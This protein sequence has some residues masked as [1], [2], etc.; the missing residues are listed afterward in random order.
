MRSEPRFILSKGS[1]V[2]Q[3]DKLKG[4]C[5]K[6]SYSFKTNEEVGYVLRDRTDCDFSIHSEESISLL[7]CPERIWFFAQGWDKEE[8]ASLLGKGI[9]R[10]VIDNPSDLEVFLQAIEDG[11]H[12]VDLLLRLRLKEHTIHTGKHFVFGFYSEQVKMMIPSLR[13]NPSIGRLG[14]H[15]HR[16]TQNVSEWSLKDE[17]IEAVGEDILGKIDLV[18]IGGGIPAEYRNF[19]QEVQNDIFKKIAELY[20]YLTSR[21]ISMMIEPGRFIAAP[22]ARLEVNVVAV[23]GQNIIVDA[24]IYQGAMDTFVSNIR[25]LVEGEREEGEAFTI[26]GR[27]PDSMDIFRYKVFMERPK[28]G[29]RITFLNAGAYTFATDFCGLK[30]IKTDI[31]E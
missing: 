11:K 5:D 12:I 25:L 8:I 16:K 24:S 26:K 15:F 19:R 23:Y 1:C 3:Y 22:S 30:K 9:R 29:D 21:H 18:D 13:E 4:H 10:F 17:L 20:S 2:S 27:T 14:I 31:I 6:V 7:A 28:L